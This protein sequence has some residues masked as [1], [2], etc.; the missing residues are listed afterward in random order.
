MGGTN[1]S[2]IGYDVSFTMPQLKRMGY[3]PIGGAMSF[4]VGAPGEGEILFVKKPARRR[5]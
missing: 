3:V 1:S 5:R 2:G 4:D